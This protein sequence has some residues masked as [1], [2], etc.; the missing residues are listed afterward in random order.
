MYK[1]IITEPA[2]QDIEQAAQYIAKELQNPA[3]ANRRLDDVES[4]VAS[5]V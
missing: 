3:A 4:A 5:Y 1:I 2:E